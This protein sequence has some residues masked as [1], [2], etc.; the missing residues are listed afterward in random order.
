M[1][2]E[3]CDLCPRRCGVNRA[4]GATG[5]CGAGILPR[6]ALVSLHRWEEPCLTGA[7]GAGTVFFSHCTMKCL[8]CQNYQISCRGTGI[9]VSVRR[10]SEIFIEQQR[11]GAASLDLV[12]PTHYAP[13]IIEALDLAKR[14]GFS[15]PVVYNCGG[16]ELPEAVEALRGWVDVFLPDL[17]YY[18]DRLARS[19][20]HA[21]DY[22]KYASASIEKMFDITGPAVIENGMMTRGVL[23]RHLILPGQTC[24]SMK[25][26][27]Y[28]HGTFGS[29]IYVSLM[30]QYTPMPQTAGIPGLN[31]RLTTLEYN[32]VLDYAE[33]LGMVNCYIQKGRTAM[34]KFIPR[35]DGRNVAVC[36]DC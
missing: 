34:E 30:N 15:L 19:Y 22:F 20:S 10:L 3:R 24:D 31:R 2:L 6:V 32:R 17:K 28:L 35:F 4:A 16:Y 29:A 7:K 36:E 13:Q 9:E 1:N 14:R 5:Y 26:L 23:V 18:D 21:P 27:D 11:R 8:F 12:T 33:S 25:V